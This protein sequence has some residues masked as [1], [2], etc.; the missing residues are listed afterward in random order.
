[1]PSSDSEFPTYLII[2]DGRVARHFAHYF[3]LLHLPYHTWSRRQD[4]QAE[5]LPELVKSHVRILVLIKDEAIPSFV[6]SHP[7]LQG[8]LCIHFSGHLTTPLAHGAHPLYTFGQDVYE[9]STYQ[10]IP[11]I[12]E[13]GDLAFA[14]LLPGL[15]NRHYR[16]PKAL[17]PFYHSLCVLSGNFTC[18]LWQKMFEEL[19]NTFHI[20]RDIAYPYMHQIVDNLQ[21]N[22][23]CALTGPLARGDKVTLESNLKALE[24]DPFQGIYQAFVHMYAQKTGQT[25]LM[26]K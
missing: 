6:T 1:M 13:E 23:A 21:K 15:N 17:K 4:P 8:K 20:P 24:L 12:L 16:I 3:H 18:L 9:L 26:P 11:F 2:G 10:Q 5:I 7:C 22:A 14:D 25:F 19:E